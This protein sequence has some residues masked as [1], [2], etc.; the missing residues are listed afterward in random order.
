MMDLAS[1]DKMFKSSAFEPTDQEIHEYKRNN[2]RARSNR[3]D[4]SASAV[5]IKRSPS[6]AG[7]IPDE[8]MSDSDDDLPDVAHMHDNPKKKKGKGRVVLSSDD[9]SEDV[10]VL[11][12]CQIGSSCPISRRWKWWT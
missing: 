2:R 3:Y 10:G 12:F 6:P 8:L 7:S 9:E 1:A 5:D 11:C 4:G